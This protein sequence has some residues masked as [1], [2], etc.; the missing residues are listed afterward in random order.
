MIKPD[1]DGLFSRYG[2]LPVWEARKWNKAKRGSTMEYAQEGRLALIESWDAAPWEEF[3]HPNQ[4]M[5]YAGIWIKRNL[6][7]MS[8]SV[9]FATTGSRSSLRRHGFH[10]NVA[11]EATEVTGLVPSY[12]DAEDLS[13]DLDAIYGAMDYLTAT[14]RRVMG[15]YYLDG[16]LNDAKVADVLGKTQQSV[17]EVRI[18]AEGRIQALILE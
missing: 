9:D 11:W 13:D 17:Q 1:M 7:I 8:A 2:F 4:F 18:R 6:G 15:L 5:A 14:Q 3:T 10:A 12:G 16:I